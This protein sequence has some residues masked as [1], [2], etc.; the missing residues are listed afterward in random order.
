MIAA[1]FDNTA[2]NA[3]Y[4]VLYVFLLYYVLIQIIPGPVRTCTRA[5][6][7]V[8][9][10]Q[11][12]WPMSESK[13]TAPLLPALLAAG[14]A[15]SRRPCSRPSLRHSAAGQQAGHRPATRADPGHLCAAQGGVAAEARPTVL[16]RRGESGSWVRIVWRWY[17]IFLIQI[18]APCIVYYTYFY[19]F[20]RIRYFLLSSP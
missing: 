16:H 11:H 20:I 12:A 9:S 18:I 14:P 13:P 3:W 5:L 17:C 4:C 8:H 19:L 6:S 1:G 15:R 2:R 7:L 10:L